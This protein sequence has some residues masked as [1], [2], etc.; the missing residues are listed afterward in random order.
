MK[1]RIWSN[2]MVTGSVIVVLSLALLA[3]FTPTSSTR[4]ESAGD[5]ET[6]LLIYGDALT[7]GWLNQSNNS[8]IN[9]NNTSPVYEGSKSVS[10]LYTKRAARLRLNRNTAISTAGYTTLRFWLHGGSAGGQQIEVHL[11][12]ANNNVLNA[13]VDVTPSAGTW[14]QINIPL[15][16]LGNPASIRGVVWHNSLNGSQPIWYI[17]RI[18]LIGSATVTPTSPGASPTPTSTATSQT[19]IYNDA[20]AGGWANWSWGTTVNF[21]NTTPVQSGSASIAATYTQG[22]AGLYLHSNNLINLSGYTTLRFYLHGGTNGGHPVAVKLADANGNYA[23][24][25]HT[26]T[27]SAGTW[28]QVNVPLANYGLTTIS[29][30]VWQENSGSTRPVMYIDNVTLVGS[31]SAT[32]TPTPPPGNITLSVNAATVVR[33]ISPNIYG[34][35]FADEALAADLRLPVNR[36]GG[37]ATTR[38]N[39]QA[40]TSNRASDWYFENIPNDN[41]NPGALPFGSASDRFA[42]RNLNTNTESLLTIPLI[43]WTPKSR[44]FACGFRVSLYGVQQN[45]DPWQPDCGNGVLSN[46][47]NITGNNPL[48]TSIA[49]GPTFVQQWINH[50]TGRYGTAANGG[51]Q[52]YNLDNEPG[53]WHIT[54]RDVHPAPLSY[55]ELRDRTYQYGA[56]V[57]AADPTAL[58]LGPAEWGWTGYFYSALDQAPGGSWWNNPLDRNAHGGLPL[59]VWYLQQMQAYQQQHG[60]RILDYLDLHFYPQASGVALSPA[61][62]TTTQALRLRS[63]QALWNPNY[64]DESWINEPVYLIPRMRQWVDQNYPGTK[65]AIGEYNWGALDHINGALTQADVLGIFGREGLDLATLWD[66]PAFNDPGAFAFRIYRNYDG[67]GRGFGNQSVTATSSNQGQVAIYAAKRSSDGALTLIVINKTAS[68]QNVTLN[69]S[70]FSPTASADVFRYSSANLAAIVQLADQ[71]VTA[72]GFTTTLPANSITLYV[73]P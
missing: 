30:I 4:V 29:G 55:D 60:V 70:G 3:I 5:A 71:T 65:L 10:V 44:G 69:L 6:E 19:V 49:I 33:T 43:G 24:Y 52:F 56:A 73:I 22:W 7:T 53:L 72:S 57:K 32:P 23:T 20:L 11:V 67:L 25:A 16:N 51:V 54:H 2:R 34:I 18:A 42:E 39:W 46:G 14:Q 50:L 31:G 40:D 12:D 15:S 59:T 63:T 47:T 17:D 37:N 66:A 45:T 48:D 62:S 8:T 36:W 9:L 41:A 64:V 21:N 35:N 58:T 27:S 26:V 1:N 61:G 68:S 13:H 28:Q 38:Y